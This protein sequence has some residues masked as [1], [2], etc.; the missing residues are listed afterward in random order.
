MTRGIRFS[1]CW[2]LAAVMASVALGLSEAAAQA[3][4][5]VAPAAAGAKAP[6]ISE[7]VVA[8]EDYVVGPGDVLSIETPGGGGQGR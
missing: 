4:S 6:A 8:P 3:S 5:A 2:T 1:I 7:G